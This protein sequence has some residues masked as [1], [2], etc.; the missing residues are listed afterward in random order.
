MKKRYINKEEID[1]IFKNIFG[2][3]KQP[4]EFIFLYNLY[5]DLDEEQRLIENKMRYRF[6]HPMNTMLISSKDRNQDSYNFSHHAIP[7]RRSSTFGFGNIIRSDS[8]DKRIVNEEPLTEVIETDKIVSI[9]IDL[10]EFT[11][12][13]IEFEIDKYNVIIKANHGESNFFKEIELLCEVDIDSAE[14]SYYN[15][16]LDVIMRRIM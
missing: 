9:T 8:S 5:N 10:P 1:N 15:G 12:E 16:V 6:S 3:L 11:K 14:I 4:W 2:N 7:L 13:N